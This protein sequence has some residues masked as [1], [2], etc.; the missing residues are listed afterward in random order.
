MGIIDLQQSFTL[1]SE[2]LKL[3]GPLITS[4]LLV[5]YFLDFVGKLIILYPVAEKKIIPFGAISM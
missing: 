5:K 2:G 4:L 1:L 3:G